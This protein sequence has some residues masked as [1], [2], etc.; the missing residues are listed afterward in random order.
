MMKSDTSKLQSKAQAVCVLQPENTGL[1]TVRSSVP[2]VT[3]V[4]FDMKPLQAIFVKHLLAIWKLVCFFLCVCFM[5]LDV[6]RQALQ[7]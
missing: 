6:L 1:I 4:S 2:C 5:F 3:C 7:L